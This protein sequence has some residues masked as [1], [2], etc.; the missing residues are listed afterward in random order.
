VAIDEV[1]FQGLL[2][3]ARESHQ[4]VEGLALSRRGVYAYVRARLRWHPEPPPLPP[5]QAMLAN[6]I[7]AMLKD[8]R[9]SSSQAWQLEQAFFLDK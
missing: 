4:R 3:R 7:V 9:L 1:N 6:E 5:G 2:N 8:P